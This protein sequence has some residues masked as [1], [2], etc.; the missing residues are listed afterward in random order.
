M[1][2]NLFNESNCNLTLTVLVDDITINYTSDGK[3]QIKDNGV[4]R[5]KIANLAVTNAKINDMDASKLTGTITIPINNS[6]VQTDKLL[7][8]DGSASVPSISF[9][10]DTNTGFY[11]FANDTISITSN[12]TEVARF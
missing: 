6:L 10:L 1:F 8:G 7:V 11:R 2:Q 9:K 5:A 3:L 4:T 12:A